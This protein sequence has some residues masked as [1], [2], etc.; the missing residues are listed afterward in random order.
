MVS[1]Y[2]LIAGIS[3]H[4]CRK[5]QPGYILDAFMQRHKYDTT[6]RMRI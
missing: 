5:M 1:I 6:H 3:W 4:D 2:A